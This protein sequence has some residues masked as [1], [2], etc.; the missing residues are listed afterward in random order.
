MT[1]NRTTS[2]PT[3]KGLTVVEL[4]I[5]L[6]ITSMVALTLATVLTAASRTMGGAS[7]ARSALQRIHAA[8]VRMRT[9][10]D[11]ALT[12]LT[13]D[14]DQGIALWQHDQ[15]PGG[16]INLTELRIFWFDDINETITVERVVF[17]DD[18]T[19]EMINA[20]DSE[21]PPFSDFFTVMASQRALG[22][23]ET[24][25]LASGFLPVGLTYNNAT[26]AESNRLTLSGQ[27]DDGAGG[28]QEMILVFALPNHQEPS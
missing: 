25:T 1:H 2:R 18:W 11:A 7:S 22:Y 4:M 9:Y 3:R 10:T 6:A 13:H 27:F 20:A 15:R 14:A 5:A 24:S 28:K 21:I 8:H 26:P 23:T 16:R 19:E 17:P 12:V